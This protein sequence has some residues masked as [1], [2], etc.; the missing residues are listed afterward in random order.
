MF[1]AKTTQRHAAAAKPSGLTQK[2]PKKAMVCAAAVALA[3]GA[4]ASGAFALDPGYRSVDIN[5]TVVIDTTKGQVIAEL[6]PQMAPKNVTQF[7][8]LA[9]QHFY[10]GL[11]FHRVMENFMDQTGDP[12]GTGEGG[13]SLPNVPGEF[14][15]RQDVNFPLN[16]ASRP[17]GSLIG[18]VGAMP[19]QSQVHELAAITADG[20]VESW[21]LFCQGAVGMARDNDP[22]S[23]NS[24]F[25]LMRDVYPSLEKN[26]TAIGVV[27][28]GVDVVRKIKIGVPAVNPDKMLKVRMLS[29]IPEAE[30][31]KIE[32]M[33]TSSPQFKAVLDQARK[34]KGA[35]FSVCDVTVPVKVNGKLT[36]ASVAAAPAPKK[37][38]PSPFVTGFSPGAVNEVPMAPS[39]ST[40]DGGG[41][42]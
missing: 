20:K 14:T 42:Y 15:I 18:Y 27:V 28:S 36:A 31:P 39:A 40:K 8:T 29:E 22:D 24:Q 25:F 38:A 5:N 21:G 4:A 2:A 3:V 6:Y 32:I 12:K 41:G 13:S 1:G 33:D 9:K 30:R 34:T 37:P 7:E 19:V 10:D 26:Y 11:I 35:D 17:A 16:V 23:A